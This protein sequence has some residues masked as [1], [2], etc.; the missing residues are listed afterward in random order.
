M[1]LLENI[2]EGLRSIKANMLRSVLT[3]LIVAIGITSLVGILTAIDGI[4]YSVNSS[5]SSLGV[6]TFDITSKRNRGS[7]AQGISE[8]RY[9]QLTFSQTVR[10]ASD[11]RSEATICLAADVTGIAEVKYLSKKTNPNVQV[12]GVNE[13]FFALKGADIEKGRNFSRIEMEY[14]S[15]VTVIGFKVAKTLFEN[16]DPIGKEI[17]FL[18]TK[19]RVIGVM[20]EKGDI[21]D[22]NYDNMVTVPLIKA[23]QMGKGRQLWYEI[24]V[25]ISDPTKMDYAMGEATGIMRSIRR[26]EIGKPNS[27]DLERS[28]SLAEELESIT[29]A[30]RIGGFGVG[31][32]TLLGAS[33]ALMNIMLVSVTERTREV[34]VRKALGATPLRIRQQFV[35]EAIVVCLLGGI[36][37]IILGIL[38]G[39]GISSLIGIDKFVVPWLWMFMGMLICVGVGLLSGYYPAHK[40][41]KLD[42]IESLRF[43]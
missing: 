39:N 29:S 1:N 5:L 40:A 18:G 20:K 13:E 32:I 8:K 10:F 9:P 7:S 17:S 24:S 16:Q 27:F 14:G 35:I 42:P 3:S 31:F 19:L 22:D 26:D 28:E 38:I 33:I 41:S 4:E 21:S 12:K 34:G 11:F 37:G 23:N 2:K 36:A 15:Q 25:G 43:E 30:L 6:N